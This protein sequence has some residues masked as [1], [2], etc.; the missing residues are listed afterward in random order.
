MTFPQPEDLSETGRSWVGAI[1]F[2]LVAAAI[3]GLAVGIS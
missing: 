1:V 2:L 3:I